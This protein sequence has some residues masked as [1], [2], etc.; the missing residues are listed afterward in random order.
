[1]AQRLRVSA[2]L[3][4]IKPFGVFSDERGIEVVK[5]ATFL[6]MK[7]INRLEFI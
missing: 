3:N 4:V 6:G 7:F 2:S 1:M 5:V